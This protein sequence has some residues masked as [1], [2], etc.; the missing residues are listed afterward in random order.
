MGE[1]LLALLTG[2]TIPAV[3]LVLKRR[4]ERNPDPW[5]RVLGDVL[6]TLLAIGGVALIVFPLAN[7]PK[8]AGAYEGFLGVVAA[9][10]FTMLSAVAVILCFFAV[11]FAIATW[12]DLERAR[13]R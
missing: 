6:A 11:I 9:L 2:I 13:N 5:Q 3:M 8:D 4:Y 1:G 12:E 10:C 7:F